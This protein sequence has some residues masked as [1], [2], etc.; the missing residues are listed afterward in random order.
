L[1]E[2]ANG[3]YNFQSSDIIEYA[4]EPQDPGNFGNPTI[5]MNVPANLAVNGE[6][7]I[8]FL[9][10][11]LAGQNGIWMLVLDRENPMPASQ[12][13]DSVCY[14]YSNTSGTRVMAG[15]GTFYSV[16][17]GNNDG[18]N[19]DNADA[20]WV[21]L[22]TALNAVPSNKL[23]FLQSIGSPVEYSLAATVQNFSANQGF[24]L[25]AKAFQAFGGTPYAVG[26]PTYTNQDNY[27]FL[28]YRGAGNALTGGAAELSTSL[29]GQ[30]GV[31][32]GTLQ[33]NSN[34]YYQPAQSSLE[35][36]GL[37]ND[38]GGI[39]DSDFLLSVAS[40]QQP[41]E[42]PSN[43]GT[44][45]LSGASSLAGQQAAFR[46]IS[47]WLLAGY[48]LKTIQGPHQDDLH[49]FFTGSV[50]TSIDYHSMDPANLQF[51][52]TGTWN[53]FGCTTSDGA[54]CTFEAPGDSAA[55]TF[56]SADFN[57]VK[58]Q[59]SLEVTYLTNT[60]QF[61]VTGSTNL[62]DVIASGNANVGLALSAAANTI[63]GSGM[64]NLNAQEIASKQVTFS[65]Q[66]LLGTLGSGLSIL[67]NFEGAGEALQLFDATKG[68]WKA[69]KAGVSIGN[70][71]GALVS[72]AGSIGSIGST[73][74]QTTFLSTSPQPFAKL[75]TTIGQLATQDLQSP[76]LTG[77]DSTVDNI[78]ADWGRLSTIGP[79]TTD[80]TDTTFFAPNQ[81]QQIAT[82]NALTTASTRSF[83]FALLPTVYNLHYWT[84]V[85]WVGAGTGF[86][87]PTVGSLQTHDEG[88]TC[89]AF[90]LSPNTADGGLGKLTPFQ[91]IAYF[92]VGSTAQPFGE[93]A[94]YVDF[95]VMDSV[96]S[97]AG[98]QNVNI[99]VID[100]DLAN[101]LFAQDQLN[102]PMYQMFSANGPMA[103]VTYDASV[104]NPSGWSNDNICDASD[105]NDWPGNSGGAITARPPGGKLLT[106]T[107]LI[108]PSSGVLGHDAVFTAQVMTGT[109]PVT[110]GSVYISVDGAVVGN[111][112][113]STSGTA[114]WTVRGG[115][116]LGKHQVQ[117]DYAPGSGYEGSSSQPSTYTVYSESADILISMTSTS[118]NASYTATSTPVSMQINSV[119][120]LAG[121][122]ALSCTGLPAGLAC[123]FNSQSLKLAADGSVNATVQIG[124]S[125]T[126]QTSTAILFLPL[127]GLGCC[128]GMDRGNA[129]RLLLAIIAIGLVTATLTGCAGGS[130]GSTPTTTRE[131]GLK[132]IT[133]NARVGSVFRSMGVTVNI[134]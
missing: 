40:F 6:T 45:L 107:S 74:T 50:N 7:Q 13:T 132:T 44:A 66:S 9:A 51:P 58:A 84:G 122:V 12:N 108:S 83:Y 18:S 87:Q 16:G 32:H 8:E 60:L 133:V 61:L 36:Q 62:K 127:L 79:R 69:A 94:G 42:W 104:S 11:A 39:S 37:F 119:A 111:S 53:G 113:I 115:V 134:Q 123:T 99:G 30:M 25:F 131:T 76:L 121:D 20:Q 55:S 82:I 85:S 41:V 35:Q 73:S 22:A 112:A 5:R 90:Y 65:W 129:R 71:V 23:V 52:I 68:L 19:R 124:P 120:G 106:S 43:S 72:T 49:F 78:T 98:T 105:A 26:G 33:R 47:H 59:V 130:M 15:C 14:D 27:A 117:A 128:F 77:F 101:N 114:S 34:G 48:Y 96:A 89:N 118:M 126:S 64:A 56:T 93:D 109:Q 86:S 21:A 91:S 110:S 38:K 2:D 81:V 10:N 75:T 63:Q 70:A 17:G 95:W 100:S 4:V 97:K 31:L 28:G 24:K 46:F 29:A 3:N 88:D 103:S 54:T 92:S 67:A 1:I 116:A 102:I 125:P 80:T 57:A